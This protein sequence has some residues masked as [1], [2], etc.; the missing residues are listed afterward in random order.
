[1]FAFRKTKKPATIPATIYVRAERMAAPTP[2]ELFDLMLIMNVRV[3]HSMGVE[4]PPAS[5]SDRQYTALPIHLKKLFV[6][7]DI[8]LKVL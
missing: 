3:P 2:D 6:R 7:K 5:I 4:L 1:M 8:D